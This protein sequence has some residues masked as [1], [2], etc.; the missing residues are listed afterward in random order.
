MQT[1]PIEIKKMILNKEHQKDSF[2]AWDN[3]KPRSL[4]NVVAVMQTF[5][6]EIKKMILN[7]EHQKDSFDAWDNLKPRSLTNVVA[8]K[9]FWD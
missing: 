5:P 8:V 3:L 6:I 7:K 1:F 9:D 4:T 2:D